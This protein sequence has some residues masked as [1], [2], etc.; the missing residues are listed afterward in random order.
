MRFIQNTS[1][2]A[3]IHISVSHILIIKGHVLVY[4]IIIKK[5]QMK[6]TSNT[7]FPVAYIISFKIFIVL[8]MKMKIILTTKKN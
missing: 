2:L 1:D 7:F 4:I 6:F 8:L 5:K 3:S